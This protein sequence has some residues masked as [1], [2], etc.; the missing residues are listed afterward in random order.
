MNIFFTF[1]V[2]HKNINA[3]VKYIG[4][5]VVCGIGMQHIYICEISFLIIIIII[6]IVWRIKNQRINAIDPPLLRSLGQYSP[7]LSKKKKQPV[8]DE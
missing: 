7:N 3:K 5:Q 2:D 6:L 1:L 8:F 4:S